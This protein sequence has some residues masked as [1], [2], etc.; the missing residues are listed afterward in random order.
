MQTLRRSLHPNISESK[1][2]NCFYPDFIMFYSVAPAHVHIFLEDFWGGPACSQSSISGT[3]SRYLG[4]E[5]EANLSCCWPSFWLVKIVFS[6]SL[7]HLLSFKSLQF[8]S[9]NICFFVSGCLSSPLLFTAWSPHWCFVNISWSSQTFTCTMRNGEHVR[10]QK[11]HWGPIS[12][13][14]FPV[15]WPVVPFFVHRVVAGLCSFALVYL[16]WFDY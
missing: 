11:D 3:F 9:R 6:V 5:T 1:R 7:V 12:I 8:T 13:S 2:F 10:A 15:S 14:I 16:E 4:W